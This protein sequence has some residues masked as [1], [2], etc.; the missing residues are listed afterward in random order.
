[1]FFKVKMAEDGYRS[2]Y[3]K[4]NRKNSTNKLFTRKQTANKQGTA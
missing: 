1:M 4:L 3:Y 2:C